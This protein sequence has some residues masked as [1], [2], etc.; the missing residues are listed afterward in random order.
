MRYPPHYKNELWK[1]E[2][3][4]AVV[5]KAQGK[6]STI[7]RTPQKSARADADA[8]SAYTLLDLS[9]RLIFFPCYIE[10][11]AWNEQISGSRLLARDNGS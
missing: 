5:I 3:N 7:T 1:K 2:K 8:R 6:M 10:L 9:S 11:R 4:I